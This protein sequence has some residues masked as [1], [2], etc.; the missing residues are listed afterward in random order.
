MLTQEKFEEII[1]EEEK[2][3]ITLGDKFQK[4]YIVGVATGIWRA[5]VITDEMYDDFM[6]EQI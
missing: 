1:K 2:A 4:G 5:R 3:S 6:M